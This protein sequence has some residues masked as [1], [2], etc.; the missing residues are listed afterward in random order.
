MGI[1]AAHHLETPY[2]SLKTGNA[3]P[4][5]ALEPM[6][7]KGVPRSPC[8]IRISEQKINTRTDFRER[9]QNLS[10]LLLVH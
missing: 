1:N 6:G 10:R 2:L 5:S 9:K 4:A 8:V 7:E 3:G